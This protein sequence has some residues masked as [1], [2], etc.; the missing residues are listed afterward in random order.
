MKNKLIIFLILTFFVSETPFAEKYRFEVSEIELT[1]NGNLINANQGKLFS[2]NNELEISAEK[3]IYNKNSDFL[4]SYNGSAFFKLSNLEIQF[5]KLEADNNNLTLSAT[6]EVKIYDLKNSINIE[7]NTAIF[8]RKNNILK[9]SGEVK[10][11]DLKNSINIE[12]KN[13]LLDKK[14]DIL[15]AI[16]EVKIY[17]LENSLNILGETLIFDKKNNTLT[18]SDEVKINDIENSLDIKAET[19]ILNKDKDILTASGKV[20]IH[21]LKNLLNIETETIILDRK[22][23]ILSSLFD[24]VLV[25]RFNNIFKTKNFEY[26]LNDNLLR[27]SNAHLKHF[28]N[29]SFKIDL[30][31]IDTNLNK[32][33][34]KD[35]LINLNNEAFNSNNQPRIKGRSIKYKDNITEIEKGIF[36]TCKKTDS[37]PPWQLSAE[38]ITHDK[39]K[40]N[41]SYENVW[42][43]IYDVPVFYFPKFFHPDPTVKRQSGFLMPTF[44]TSPNKNTYL[45]LPYFKVIDE[46]KDLTFTPRLYAKDQ[47]LIQSEYRE[48]SKN[49]SA[50]SDI[51]VLND[52]NKKLKSH[53]FY[54]FNKDLNI[55]NF[56]Q[57]NISLNIEKVS[58]DTYLKANKIIS[59]IIKNY[60]V[61]ETSIK[62]DATSEDLS[63]KTDFI[64]FE[65]LNK[66]S[67][68]RYEYIF[69]KVDLTKKI[70]NKTKLNGNFLFK[71]NNYFQNYETNVFEKVNNNDLI[72]NSNPKINNKGFYNNY[73]FVIKNSNTDSQNSSSFKEGSDFYISG[74]FQFNSS[75]PLIKNKNGYQKLIKP[76]ISLKLSPNYT[77]NISEN[78]NRLDV[79][80]IYNL[81]RLSSSETLEGGISLTYGNDFII[82]DQKNSREILSF[83]LANNIRLKENEDLEN[84]NQLGAKTSNLFAEA[85]YSPNSYLTTSY[86]ISTKNNF[87][88]VN[89]ENL[90]AKIN[91]K[92][93]VT[94]FDYL[95]ENDSGKNTYLLNKTTY[96]FNES[97]NLSFSVREN[98]KTSLTEYYNLIYQYKNDCLAATIEYNKEYYNDRDIKP[99]ESIFFKLTIIPFGETSTPN[100]R[101]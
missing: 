80:N 46:S 24:S 68:D 5:K 20:K 76:K 48:V 47:I 2:E 56:N 23:N 13:V 15:T 50:I 9:A 97:N 22:N 21:D 26:K 88:E 19:I 62:L 31:Y 27:I 98:K 87:H 101:K 28:D 65:N 17:N 99:E 45:S 94:T 84:N 78:D 38:K 3:F 54:N 71:S 92:N 58:N 39:V 83:K 44:K 66:K 35:I 8:D 1:N 96:N 11:Y 4:E 63:I 85:K 60:D 32:F 100:L 52:S 37:C 74:L 41:I 49:S 69:P 81:D 90:T 51:S 70:K 53:F 91:I 55:K 25:D 18:I 29:N 59:P 77:K 30:A 75:L 79:N 14:K 7:A 95:N 89:Y 33:T 6:D 43:E 42:L 67:S 82:T 73:E 10:I 86:N 64:I 93:L 12:A 34:G 36:T 61:L 72:F 16:G 40:K 57:S